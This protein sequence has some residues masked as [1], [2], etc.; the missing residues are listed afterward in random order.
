MNGR[1]WDLSGD[2]PQPH[3]TLYFSEC[4]LL[5]LNLQQGN[6][7]TAG[8]EGWKAPCLWMTATKCGG[9]MPVASELSAKA[10]DILCC[11]PMQRWRINSSCILPLPFL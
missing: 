1:L 2:D 6:L 8:P 5:K 4:G 11:L 10:S 3:P 7:P 9:K